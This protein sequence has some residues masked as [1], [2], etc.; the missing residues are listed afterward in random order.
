[1]ATTPASLGTTGKSKRSPLLGRGRYG[2]SRILPYLF[3]L[4]HLILFGTF[5][6]FAT[7]LGFYVSLHS[8]SFLRQTQGK[9]NPFIGLRNYE[10]LL[11]EPG[12][13]YH[14]RFFDAL[15]NTFLFVLMTVPVLVILGML[16]ANLLNAKFW[17][18]TFFRAL[19][20]APWALS[21]SVISLLWAFIFADPNEGVVNLALQ[22]LHIPQI[23]W[24]AEKM[25][26]WTAISVAT[27][28]W[29]VGFNIVILLAALQNVPETL[30][31]AAQIDGAGAI[32]RFVFITLPSLRSVLLFVVINQLLASFNQFGQSN[33][34]TGGAPSDTTFTVTMRIWDTGWTNDTMGMAAAMGFVFASILVLF[35]V[36]SFRALGSDAS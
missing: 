23:G 5:I 7:L 20:L 14:Q 36:I 34:M 12:N 27:V 30:Y 19:Y 1:M 32:A 26:A 18:R 28:W 15:G 13:L 3:I 2:E 33:I 35:S 16:L 29:T 24:F 25:S 22:T 21:V 10:H 4:P 8:F 6:G 17:G 9:P 11:F 31:E